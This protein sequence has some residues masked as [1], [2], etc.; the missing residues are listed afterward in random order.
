MKRSEKIK[1]LIAMGEASSVEEA[2][3]ILEDMGE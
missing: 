2:R 3:G 1:T